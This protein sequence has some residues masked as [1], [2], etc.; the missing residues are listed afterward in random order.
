MRDELRRHWPRA[1]SGGSDVPR[2]K[3]WGRN[4]FRICRPNER[5]HGAAKRQALARV[6]TRRRGLR[7]GKPTRYPVG[8]SGSYS[9]AVP[10][11]SADDWCGKTARGVPGTPGRDE[12][13][14]ET[15]YSRA[16]EAPADERAG[17][18]GSPK[19]PRYFTTLLSL[20]GTFIPSYLDAT[21]SL[22]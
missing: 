4:N 13:E 20:T 22:N 2:N 18:I 5:P 9:G 19:P 12:R 1:V 17:R 3:E 8:K 11:P 21:W 6:H 7:R 15:E 16:N 10:K 14:V